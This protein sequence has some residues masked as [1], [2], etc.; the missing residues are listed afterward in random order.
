MAP[1]LKLP[2]EFAAA[3]LRSW[4]VRRGWTCVG[5]RRVRAGAIAYC[6]S[7]LQTYEGEL[8]LSRCEEHGIGAPTAQQRVADGEIQP[9][10]S[11]QPEILF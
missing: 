1:S 9:I 8:C 4:Q 2:R 6:T 5:E 7:P 10:F 11:P 3:R